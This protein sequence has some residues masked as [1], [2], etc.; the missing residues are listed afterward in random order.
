[1]IAAVDHFGTN[2]FWWFFVGM[3]SSRW[4]ASRRKLLC[5]VSTLSLILAA[6][7]LVRKNSS[8]GR[9]HLPPDNSRQST[10]QIRTML[11]SVGLDENC[12][13]SDRKACIFPTEIE[14]RGDKKF[15]GGGKG[16]IS[17]D[18]NAWGT[19]DPVTNVPRLSCQDTVHHAHY[20]RFK[21]TKEERTGLSSYCPG[22]EC[23]APTNRSASISFQK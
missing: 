21:L 2:L 8:G 5:T 16:K 4:L 23:I 18:V 3:V 7:I 12:D 15:P 19:F 17:S 11:D 1:M 20:T 6:I 14:D 9:Q 22:G 13:C 10:S